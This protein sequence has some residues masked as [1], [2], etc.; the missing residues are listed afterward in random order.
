MRTPWSRW[1]TLRNQILVVFVV[2]MAIVLTLVGLMTFHLVSRLITNNAEKQI[3]QT[4]VEATGRLETLYRQIDTLSNQVA[5][6]SE[7]QQLLLQVAEGHPATFNERQALM[8]NVS[9]FQVYSDGISSFDLYTNDY[10]RLFPNDAITLLGRI[11]PLW[12]E[13]ADRAQGRMVWIGED[14]RDPAYLLAV[15]QVR[16]MDR[17]FSGGGYLLIRINRSY[18]NL[19]V[20]G[21]AAGQPEYMMLVDKSGNPIASN[22]AGDVDAILNDRQQ[23]VAING[24]DYIAVKMTAEATGWTLVILSPVSALTEGISVLRTA[25]V[26]SG[27]VGFLIVLISSLL[28]STMMTRPILRLIKTMRSARLGELK[29]SPAIQSTAEIN[30]LTR[31]YNEMVDNINHLIEVIYE[32]ELVRSRAELKALQAQIN[33]HFLYNTLE[34]LYWS[35]QDKDEE[36]LAELVVAMSELFRYTIGGSSKD[37][38]VAV[39]AELEHVERYLQLMK[40]RFGDRLV[41]DIQTSPGAEQARIPKLLI[42]PLVENALLHGLGNKKGPGSV[43]ITVGPSAD[44]AGWTIAVCDDGVG[45]DEVTVQRVIR[46]LEGGGVPVGTGTGLAIA[47]VSQR[48][49]LAYPEASGGLTLQSERGQGTCVSFDIPGGG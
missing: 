11:G 10:L 14:T 47:N 45:M 16:L 19:E 13:Q 41:W 7:V 46:S 23:Q 33:P 32:K 31:T 18:F 4:A 3:R 5:T 12:L 28:L 38:W 40:L 22:Y 24:Q 36:E 26:A 49:R 27:G 37:E 25:I 8:Q 42:Q 29:P 17:W 2:V 35:L 39:S 43:T 15:R 20:P 48:L 6:N 44:A 1:N 30:E 34:A 9:A 21:S